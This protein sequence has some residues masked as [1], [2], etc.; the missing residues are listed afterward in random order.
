MEASDKAK[1]LLVQ[2]QDRV[3]D[4]SVEAASGDAY[5]VMSATLDLKKA[6]TE[7]LDYIATLEAKQ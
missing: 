6:Q 5:G 1:E 2:V 4:F 3:V 7:L